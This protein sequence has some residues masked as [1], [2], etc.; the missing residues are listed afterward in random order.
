MLAIDRPGYG[1]SASGLAKGQLLAEQVATLRAALTRYTAL[2]PAGAGVFLL[3]HSYGGKV[4]L[5]IA[6]EERGAGILGLDVSGLG[7]R[8]A[9]NP[10]EA[11][12]HPDHRDWALHWGPLGLYPPRTFRLAAPLV[13]EIPA[14][15]RDETAAWP[16]RFRGIAARVQVPVRLTFAEHE[17]WWRTDEESL[18]E[19]RELLSAPR[20]VVERLPHAG[21]NISLGLAART[22]H[23]RA[24][25]F[26]DECLTS[27]ALASRAQHTA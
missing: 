4:A 19:I 9:V 26:L 6:A 12:E 25:A 13:S 16:D 17:G 20:V 14:L 5:A 22:Y 3:G 1:L 8:Y 24:L 27:S 23:L 2:C 15:E 11:I 10:E 21:H 18:A 7:R